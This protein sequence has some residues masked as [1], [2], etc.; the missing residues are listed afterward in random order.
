MSNGHLEREYKAKKYTKR[1][2]VMI[3]VVLEENIEKHI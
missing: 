2:M 3:F 1:W